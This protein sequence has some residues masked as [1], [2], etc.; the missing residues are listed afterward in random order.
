M[1]KQ[2]WAS[3]LFLVLCASASW[4]TITWANNPNVLLVITDEHNF[5]TLGCYRE[6]MSRD[7][8]EMWGED[9]IVET[10]HFD[11][12]AHEGVICTRAYATA[13]VCTPSRA[14]M[15]SG[16]YPHS[17]GAPQNNIPIRTDIP[18]LATILNKEGYRSSFVGKWHLGGT[19]KPEWA[20][21]IDGGFQE[22]STMFNRGHWK[23]FVT[24]DEG[25]RVGSKDKKGNPSYGVDGADATTFSTDYLTDRVIDFIQAEN[26]KPFFVTVSYPDPHGPNT[27]RAPYDHMFDDLRFTQPRTY[28]Q[29]QAVK[30]KWLAGGSKNHAKFRGD[31][32]SKYFGMVK[33]LDDNLGRLLASLKDSGKLDSTI[34]L[35]TS[36]HGDLCYEHDRLNKGN[37]YE[38]SARVPMLLRYP[39]RL[40]RG[41]VYKDPMGTVDITPTILGLADIATGNIFEGRDLS[42]QLR[43]SALDKNAVTFLRNGG[44]TPAW[45]AAIDHRYKLILSVKDSPW[46]F[47]S[48]SDPDELLNFYGRPGTA[49]PTARLARALLQ[50]SQRVRDSFVEE[51]NIAKSMKRCLSAMSSATQ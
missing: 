38:G 26:D 19:G 50:H 27:V 29:D 49:E 46:L 30:P 12:L 44:T 45:V 25:P 8:G 18:T 3:A 10:P 6:Q 7:Q 9:V 1:I 42:D 51:P 47:D 15:I 16:R 5:R 4:A 13:P 31:Q 2:S 43:T 20:P 17:A 40:N 28:G 41:V 35:L 23:K 11:S 21:K 48:E 33:C 36:D 39:A 37:P 32:M 34:I 24:T 22:K 14:A